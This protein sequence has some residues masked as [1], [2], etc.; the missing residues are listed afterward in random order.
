MLE[1]LKKTLEEAP[2][3]PMGDYDYVVHPITDGVPYIEP[4]LLEEVI[5]EIMRDL[6]E[7][8]L[9]VTAEAMGIPIAT[10]LSLRTR[11]PFNIIRKRRYG[12]PGEVSVSQ[13]TGY[14]KA[15]LF[16]NGL[17]KGDRILFV[18]DVLSTGGTLRATLKAL[19]GIGVEVMGVIIAVE[20][21]DG[22][23]RKEINEEFGVNIR[24]LVNY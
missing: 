6:P 3:V 2:V 11:K 9:I 5:E 24:T 4:E 21:G 17:K 1:L 10:A 13:V 15:K 18:D 7:F 22:E 19:K 20:K 8:D 16:I 14:S 12:L 23:I